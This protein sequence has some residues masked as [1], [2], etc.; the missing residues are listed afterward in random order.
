MAP[1]IER[2]ALLGLGLGAAALGLAPSVVRAA[3]RGPDAASQLLGGA[4]TLVTGVGT[5]VLVLSSPAGSLL[6]DTGHAD[7]RG[8]LRSQ[9]GRLP[10]KGRVEHVI[11]THWHRDHT[12]SN[13]VFGKAGASIL[14]HVK[15]R[16]HV[17]IDLWQPDSQAYL[18]A[19]PKPAWPTKTF[20]QTQA[21]DFAGEHVECGYLLEAH[22]DGDIYVRFVQANVLAV[23]GAL[24]APG[25]DP[26]LDWFGGG[27][28][29]GRIDSLAALLKIADDATRVVPARGP[30]L[31]RRELQAEY[32]TL[33]PLL[34]R[35]AGLMRKGFTT[36]D[37]IASNVLDTTGRKWKDG[38][39]FLYSAH[40]G[41]W[42][43]HNTLS[44]DIV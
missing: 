10:G 3:A 27:W 31:S 38:A 18:K 13:E 44:H 29:G 22:T 28:L 24:A 6:V 34:D 33:A 37:M 36:E 11:N 30:V 19:L 20:H 8:A 17:A 16:Q 32:D 21:L 35:L 26:E 43:H 15:T 9:L 12:G 41:L 1:L 14:A 40:K 5:N 7:R 25:E 42:A 4:V 23:G 2:R 39:K